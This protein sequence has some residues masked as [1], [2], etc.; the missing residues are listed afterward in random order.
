MKTIELP[1]DFS[2]FLAACDKHGIIINK[3][4]ETPLAGQE[5]DNG[6][7]VEFD[8]DKYAVFYEGEFG[9]LYKAEQESGV[10]VMPF[11]MKGVGAR[12]AQELHDTDKY[13]EFY[14]AK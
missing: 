10:R 9:N 5:V 13:E 7:G 2:R 11:S 4:F 1:K 14:N 6:M 8:L 12:L 3:A